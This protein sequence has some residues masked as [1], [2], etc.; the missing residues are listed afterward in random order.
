M[1]F[2]VAL[3][4]QLIYVFFLPI[5]KISTKFHCLKEGKSNN[6]F[7][8]IATDIRKISSLNMKRISAENNDLEIM[9]LNYYHQYFMS[10]RAIDFLIN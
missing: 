7:V 6:N 10:H 8:K 9:A 4:C 2:V 5:E 3:F 1:Y